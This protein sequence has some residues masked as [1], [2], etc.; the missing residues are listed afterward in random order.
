M[1][2]VCCQLAVALGLIGTFAASLA[3]EGQPVTLEV[4]PGTITVADST[5]QTVAVIARNTGDAAVQDARLSWLASPG[6]EVRTAA[7]EKRALGPGSAGRWNVDVSLKDDTREA[8]SIHFFAAY[9]VGKAGEPSAENI[10]H[11]TLAVQRPPPI[12]VDKVLDLRVESSLK[13]LQ[14]RRDGILHVIARNKGAVPLKLKFISRKAPSDVNTNWLVEPRNVEIAPQNEVAFELQLEATDAVLPGKHLLLLVV[15]VEWVQ[16][17]VTRTGSTTLKYEFDAGVIGESEILTAIGVPTFLLLPGFLCIV[18][19]GL[20]WNHI[21]KRSPITMDLKDGTFWTL[22]VTLSLLAMSVYPM[23]TNRDYLSGYGLKDIKFVWFG[24]SLAGVVA[25]GGTIAAVEGWALWQK[26]LRSR[27]TFA[28][29]DPAEEVLRKLARL[30]QGVRLKRLDATVGTQKV[31]G[32]LLQSDAGRGVSWIA[33]PMTLSFADSVPEE[34][35]PEI[36]NQFA[37]I[38][39]SDDVIRGLLEFLGPGGTADAAIML[40]WVKTQ[41]FTGVMEVAGGTVVPTM[42][43]IVQLPE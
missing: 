22:A 30:G 2:L 35:R 14:E 7:V 15:A 18:M 26:Y 9:V 27:I 20:C 1:K 39:E 40:R 25:C 42:Q 28:P 29:N 11:A 16:D 24:A 37:R 10:A 12:D 5:V 34:E 41:N 3:A 33:P 23:I 8:G 21:A 36:E 17:D 19:F 13:M 38:L 43:S 4:L 31:R 32:F 6:C